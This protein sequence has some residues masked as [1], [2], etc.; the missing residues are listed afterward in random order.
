[1]G[2]IDAVIER[3]ANRPQANMLLEDLETL[4]VCGLFDNHK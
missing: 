2:D 3:K 4:L 1:M